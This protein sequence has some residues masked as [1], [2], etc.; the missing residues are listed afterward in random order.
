M[1]KIIASIAMALILAVSM[2]SA[3]ALEYPDISGHWAEN[4]IK[5]SDFAGLL[6]E[7]GSFLPNRAI[8]KMEFVRILHN[9]LGIEI[10]SFKAPDIKEF[11]GDLD[12]E[13]TGA[14]ELYDMVICGIIPSSGEF[15]PDEPL[16]R[17]EM[18]HYIISALDY[19]TDG[20][21]ALIMMMP[22]PFDDDA[23][24]NP[25]YKN[26][27]VK[28]VLLKIINGRNGSMLFPDAPATRA[29]AVV[30]VGRLLDTVKN[31][32]DVDVKAEAVLSDDNIEMKLS[33]TNNT[34]KAISIE[35][36]SGQKYDFKLFD[37]EGNNLYTWSAD[38]MFILLMGETVIEPGETVEFSEVLEGDAYAAIKDRIHSMQAFIVGSSD[39]FAINPLGYVSYASDAPVALP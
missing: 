33:I 34:K 36:T 8:T 32:S 26:D 9:A 30:A 31:L 1:K 37:S 12:N 5:E 11:F 14:S 17:D 29:E 13:D 7:D 20:E 27:V 16:R 39:N 10:N 19:M 6:G 3:G 35:H 24:I 4:H 2:L 22:E 23:K 18:I 15:R 25:D 38:K 21:Y 28:A